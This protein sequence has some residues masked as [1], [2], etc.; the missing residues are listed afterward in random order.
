[1]LYLLALIGLVTVAVL[2]WKAFGPTTNPMLSK[3]VVGPDDDP[4]FL[5]KVDREA[6]RRKPEEPG[7]GSSD[8]IG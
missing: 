7:T 1:M 3:R 8:P 4:E 2:L 5:W 6:H